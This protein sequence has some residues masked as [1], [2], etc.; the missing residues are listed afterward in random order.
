[1]KREVKD[2][3]VVAGSEARK[4]VWESTAK[5]LECWVLKRP[6]ILMDTRIL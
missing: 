1:M 5:G 3:V 6:P 2:V 4:V